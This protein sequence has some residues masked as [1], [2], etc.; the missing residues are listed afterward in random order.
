VSKIKCLFKK[1]NTLGVVR[2]TLKNKIDGKMIKMKRN[3]HNNE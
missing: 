2:V 3:N 1:V